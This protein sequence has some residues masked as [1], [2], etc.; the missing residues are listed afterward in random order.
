MTYSNWQDKYKSSLITFAEAAQKVK[1][2]DF[3]TTALGLGA[4][5]SEFFEKI[6]DRQEELQEVII[7]DSMQ[8]RPCRL[9]DPVFMQN[10]AG[11]IKYSPAFGLASI[12]A[13]YSANCD[14]LINNLTDSGD[15]LLQRSS[16]F[17][18]QVT[19]PDSRGYMNLGLS[20]DFSLQML[21][22]KSRGNLRLAIGEINDQMPIVYGNNWVHV[23]DFDYFIENS[24]A[25]P[26]FKRNPPTETE[27]AVADYVLELIADGSTIQM[28]LGGISEAVFS[29]LTGKKG[30]GVHSE[31]LPVSLPRLVE[32]GMVD[33]KNKPLHSGVSVGT[34]CLGDENMYKFV[35]ENPAVE[36]HPGYYINKSSLLAQIPN[37]VAVNMGLLVDFSGQIASEG[38]GYRMIS[39]SGGQL[40]FA[41]GAFWSPGGKSVTLLRSAQKSADGTLVSSIL[42]GLPEGTPVTVPRTFADYVI[43]EYGIANLRYKTRQERANALINIAHPELRSDLRKQMQKLFY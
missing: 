8:L 43:T 36:L 18:C 7:S 21:K 13:S 27:K 35:A 10:L 6:L 5:S 32:E 30:L 19:P 41:M 4:C 16:I 24:C 34:F 28:G 42:P 37:L 31:M 15:K 1:S 20:N 26:V 14:Y 12:R 11:H 40:D 3:I 9:Y 22:N 2:G 25:L 17:I 33:N 29:G 23:S 39:G 38:L